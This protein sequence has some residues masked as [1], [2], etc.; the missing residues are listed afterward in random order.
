MKTL[1]K[2]TISIIVVLLIF[3]LIFSSCISGNTD[4]AYKAGYN[5]GYADGL[6]AEASRDAGLSTAMSTAVP[7]AT[8]VLINEIG[9]RKNPIQVGDTVTYEIDEFIYGKGILEISYTNLT[10]GDE[11][12]KIIAEANQ[13]NEEAGEGYEYAILYFDIK[14]VQDKSANDTPIEVNSSQFIHADESFAVASGFDILAIALDT[15]L[16]AKLYEGA[17][18]S[19]SVVLKIPSGDMGYAVFLDTLWFAL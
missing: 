15:R 5:E 14:N 17:S 1:S 2:K 10:R 13:F 6:A 18:T 8:P 4:A 19:G 9:S 7:T 3:P 11:A 12:A 16:S